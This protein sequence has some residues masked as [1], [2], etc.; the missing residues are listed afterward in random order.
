MLRYTEALRNNKRAAL[1]IFENQCF[2]HF[3]DSLN[4]DTKRLTGLS[5]GA[6]VKEAEPFTIEREEKLWNSLGDVSASVQLRTM[7]FLVGKNI[8]AFEATKSIAT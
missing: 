5:L 8:A 4:A 1:E 2:K 6:R 7:V 3:Q